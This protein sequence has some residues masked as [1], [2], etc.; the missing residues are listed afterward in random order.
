VVDKAKQTAESKG[1]TLTFSADD[2]GAPYTFNGDKGKIGDNVL[3]NLIDNA[4]NY[5]PSG[6]ISVSLKKDGS[7][8]IF[9][10][11]DTGVGINEEDKKRLF[12][13]GGH[14]KDSQTVNVHST[15]YGLYIA[16]NIVDAHNGTIR[17]E[18]EGEGKGATFVVELPA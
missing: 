11:K 7:K 4:I 10:V 15:G 18:S 1:L 9:A 2:T 17:A 12:T 5:T 14:G 3:H 13:E 6:S 8:F 16:K